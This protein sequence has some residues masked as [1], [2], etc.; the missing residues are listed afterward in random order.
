MDTMHAFASQTQ[1]IEM[2]KDFSII[3]KPFKHQFL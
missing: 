1:L 2:L 3:Q